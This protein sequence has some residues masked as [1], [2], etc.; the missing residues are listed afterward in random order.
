VSTRASALRNEG[1]GAPARAHP[2]RRGSAAAF[3]MREAGLSRPDRREAGPGHRAGRQEAHHA[4]EG[5]DER[6]AADDGTPAGRAGRQPG[7]LPPPGR[8]RSHRR[9]PRP[10]EGPPG[11]AHLPRQRH[12]SR[13]RRG[14]AAGA[15]RS[16]PAG[17]GASGRLAAHPRGPGV[18]HGDQGGPQRAPGRAVRSRRARAR[19]LPRDERALREDARP[20]L[21]R[22]RDPRPPAGGAQVLRRPPGRQVDLAVPHRHLG[23]RSASARLP[24]AAGPRVRRADLH[25]AGVPAPRSR[26]PAPGA[27]RPGHRSPGDEE[28]RPAPRRVSP[29]DGGLGHR[30]QP[31]P[32]RAGLAVRPLEGSPGG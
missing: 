25:D 4:T 12:R 3:M 22:V 20:A 19:H 23:A 1:N 32:P 28:R 11:A 14:R 16:G 2:E 29:N 13:G 8:G 5:A 6:S 30:H 24:G 10:G 7:A 15:A 18:L 27:H 9:A 17:A 21:R 31:S 26:G